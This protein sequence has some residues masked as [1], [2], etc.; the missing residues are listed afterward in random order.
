MTFE[1]RPKLK[2]LLD[3]VGYQGDDCLIFP[4]VL[5]QSGYG[6]F[7]VNKKVMAAHRWM[8]EQRNGPPPTSKHHAAH[9]CGN[10][11]Q[12]CVTPKHLSW[13][14]NA[15]NQLDRRAHGT[16]KLGQARWKLTPEKVA[17]IRALK[18]REPIKSLAD[19]FG[20]KDA[21]IRQIHS[22]RI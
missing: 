1:K 14:T 6:N 3:H 20:V 7:M 21:T 5:C 22:G 4:F 11:E 18:N 10:G 13:K 19:R 17:E 15:Q 8:C 12:G 2:W 9:S 16:S